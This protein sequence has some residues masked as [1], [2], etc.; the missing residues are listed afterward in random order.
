MERRTPHRIVRGPRFTDEALASYRVT[1]RPTTD[2]IPGYWRLVVINE[3]KARIRQYPHAQHDRAL[4]HF[5][6]F[7]TARASATDF[8]VS[9]ENASGQL[10]DEFERRMG[11]TFRPPAGA[12]QIVQPSMPNAHVG[13]L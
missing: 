3:G 8:Y 4:A 12:H 6:W 13:E 9:L 2:L 1:A 7:V 11:D 5:G 10:V